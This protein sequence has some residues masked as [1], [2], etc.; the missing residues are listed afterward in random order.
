MNYKFDISP[1]H[2]V[3]MHEKQLLL[4]CVC[5]PAVPGSVVVEDKLLFFWWNFA[6]N[7]K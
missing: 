5:L 4:V 6:I 7:M 3:Y 2:W 1:G